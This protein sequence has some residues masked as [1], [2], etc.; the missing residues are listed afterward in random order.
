VQ[1]GGS[2]RYTGEPA[3]HALKSDGGSI[4]KY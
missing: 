2:I 4:R 3:I 1:D